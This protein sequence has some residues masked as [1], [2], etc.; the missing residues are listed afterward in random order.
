MKGLK[1]DDTNN[2]LDELELLGSWTYNHEQN[3]DSSSVCIGLHVNLVRL[4]FGKRFF[5]SSYLR[6]LNDRRIKNISEILLGL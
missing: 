6:C 4:Q 1:S 5:L 3:N 2:E